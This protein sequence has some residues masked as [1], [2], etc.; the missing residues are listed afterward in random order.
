ML[1]N[2][3]GIAGIALEDDMANK[4]SKLVCSGDEHELADFMASDTCQKLIVG[5]KE[6]AS[7]DLVVCSACNKLSLFELDEIANKNA[8]LPCR[9]CGTK[10]LVPDLVT[11]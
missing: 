5:K 6:H 4:V 3:A 9:H 7:T 10:I 2:I 8:T 1:L 11:D